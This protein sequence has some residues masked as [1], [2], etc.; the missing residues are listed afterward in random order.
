MNVLSLFDGISIGQLALHKVGLTVDNYYA[1]EINK[2]SM[3]VT[4]H[5]FPKTI[6]LG[7]VCDWK[8]WNIDW[9]K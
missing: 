4:Q 7:D 6:Q 8:N 3:N 2:F 5:H 9:D 1:S